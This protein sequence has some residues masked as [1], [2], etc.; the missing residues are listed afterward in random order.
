MVPS[1]FV[2]LPDLPRTPNLKVDRKSLP[3]PDQALAAGKKEIVSAHDDTERA[4]LAIW[5]RVLGTEDV[6]VEDN[7]FDAGGHSILAVRVHREIVEQLGVDLQVTDL[8]R[9]TT[10]ASLGKHLQAGRSGP[11]A[12]QQ[13]R[14]RAE[15]R[16]RPM[17][18]S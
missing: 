3:A 7:F 6:G 11:T 17:R 4:I 5:R 13:A 10:V 8:F 15:M 2:V 18:R 12:V 16:R 1:W 14:A 9:F